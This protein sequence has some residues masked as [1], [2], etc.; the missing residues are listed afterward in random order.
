MKPLLQWTRRLPTPRKVAAILLSALAVWVSV[1][2]GVSV[3]VNQIQK[4]QSFLRS[5]GP[6]KADFAVAVAEIDDRSHIIGP[7]KC[8]EINA[9]AIPYR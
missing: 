5:R 9:K 2:G 7:D 4:V 3:V 8:H 6:M 1:S